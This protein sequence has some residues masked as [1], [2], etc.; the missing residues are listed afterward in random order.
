MN[1]RRQGWVLGIACLLIGLGPTAGQADR[2]VALGG[3]HA[4]GYQ[5]WPNA[6]TNLHDA[7]AAATNGEIV[8]MSN[9]TFVVTGQVTVATNITIKG[10]FGRDETVLTG[11]LPD[12][13]NRCFTVNHADAWL[14]SLTLSNFYCGVAGGG[15]LYLTQGNVTN[16]VFLGNRSGAGHYGAAIYTAGTWAGRIAYCLFRANTASNYGGGISGRRSERHGARLHVYR[17]FRVSG[18]RGVLPGQLQGDGGKL[19]PA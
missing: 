2:Y 19:H 8:W 17:K 5:T 13:T 18:W 14:D 9:D 4:A 12:Y 16:C 11:A 3:G 7:V 1:A 15:A 10:Y 6:A